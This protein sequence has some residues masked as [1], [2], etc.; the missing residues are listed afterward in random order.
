MYHLAD[1]L[2]AD[3]A[4]LV[5]MYVNLPLVTDEDIERALEQ[6]QGA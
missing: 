2:S 5:P 4:L 6:E 1:S 3:Q